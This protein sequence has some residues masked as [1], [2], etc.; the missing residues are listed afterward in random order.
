M[1]TRTIT[2]CDGCGLEIDGTAPFMMFFNRLEPVAPP[3][4]HFHRLECVSAWAQREQ[5]KVSSPRPTV[6]TVLE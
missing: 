6:K 5:E 2:T 4:R 3:N 1:T